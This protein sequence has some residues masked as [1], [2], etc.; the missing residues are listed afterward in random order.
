MSILCT[1]FIII[2]IIYLL[3][4]VQQ[5]AQAIGQVKHSERDSKAH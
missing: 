2:I 3:I 4:K 5:Y 1:M